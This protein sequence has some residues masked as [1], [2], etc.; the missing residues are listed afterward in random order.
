MKL[1]KFKDVLKADKERQKIEYNEQEI[2]EERMQNNYNGNKL[3]TLERLKSS[4]LRNIQTSKHSQN[5]SNKLKYELEIQKGSRIISY[6][7]KHNV[8]FAP[9][10]IKSYGN[11]YNNHLIKTNFNFNKIPELYNNK[12]NVHYNNDCNVDVLPTQS[13]TQNNFFK[14]QSPFIEGEPL[15][16]R[17]GKLDSDIDM[18]F[19]SFK[20][21]FLLKFTKNINQYDKVIKSIESMCQFNKKPFFDGIY[22]LKYLSEKKDKILLENNNKNLNYSMWKETIIFIHEFECIWQKLIE[23]SFKEL[24]KY[25]DSNIMILKKNNDQEEDLQNKTKKIEE[26]NEYIRVNELETKVAKFQKTLEMIEDV[27]SQYEKRENKAM[28]EMFNMENK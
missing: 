4:D 5:S 21:N 16:D 8:K 2:A 17:N 6:V 12:A 27:K 10:D 28:I 15:S 1:K 22:K 23:S 11:S 26:L 24:K 9:S 7:P 3:Y 19:L 20:T 14:F 25:S 13:K 18:D